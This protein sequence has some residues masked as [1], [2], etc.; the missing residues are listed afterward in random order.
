MRK[1]RRVGR[2]GKRGKIHKVE[3]YVKE[4]HNLLNIYSKKGI[5]E[6]FLFGC[7]I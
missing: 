5:Q 7:P 1:T 4:N 2:R 6:L 3:L